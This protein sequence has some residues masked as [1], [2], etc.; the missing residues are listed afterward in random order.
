MA[1]QVAVSDVKRL[2][3][4]QDQNAKLEKLLAE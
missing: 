1:R 4:P 3:A 2:K